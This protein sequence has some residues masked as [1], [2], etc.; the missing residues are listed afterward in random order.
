MKRLSAIYSEQE[1]GFWVATVKNHPFIRVTDAPCLDSA[2]LLLLK[3]ISEELNEKFKPI[4]QDFEI[5]EETIW[6]RTI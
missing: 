3:Y 2:R 5:T 6:T 4:R 1:G